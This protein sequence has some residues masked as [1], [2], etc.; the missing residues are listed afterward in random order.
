MKQDGDRLGRYLWNAVVGEAPAAEATDGS[1]AL[2][3]LRTPARID[4]LP[5]NQVPIP[6]SLATKTNQIGWELPLVLVEHS[7]DPV[8]LRELASPRGLNSLAPCTFAY[9]KSGS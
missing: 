2:D 1:Q 5:R 6:G 4:F 3:C 7:G 8:P 9:T